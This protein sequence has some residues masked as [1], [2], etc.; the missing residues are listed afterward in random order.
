M[1]ER[2]TGGKRREWGLGD[3]ARVFHT[4]SKYIQEIIKLKLMKSR[5]S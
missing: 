2:G 3:K 4:S 5:L 1:I